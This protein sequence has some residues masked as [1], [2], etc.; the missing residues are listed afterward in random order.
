MGSSPARVAG[1][2]GGGSLMDDVLEEVRD[3][4]LPH[5]LRHGA[6]PDPQVGGHPG[7]RR[8]SS[9]SRMV[10][11]LSSTCSW[12]GSD[13]E[14]TWAASAGEPAH[15]PAKK[16]TSRALIAV[17]YGLGSP[18]LRAGGRHSGHSESSGIARRSRGIR[19]GSSDAR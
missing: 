10:K 16:R 5:R 13:A 15:A 3:A 8:W 7:H 12:I 19:S 11:P 9:T 14:E 17:P 1:A 2:D 6:D 4:V 18:W